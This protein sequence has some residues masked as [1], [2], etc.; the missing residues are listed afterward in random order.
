MA[1]NNEFKKLYKLKNLQ[2][3]GENLTE[4]VINYRKF[5]QIFNN[6][7]KNIL[8]NCEKFCKTYLKVNEILLKIWKTIK[9]QSFEK[10]IKLGRK[11]G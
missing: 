10:F 9:V 8:K 5:M 2:I 11:L 7:S 6:I 4:I 1:I 3:L